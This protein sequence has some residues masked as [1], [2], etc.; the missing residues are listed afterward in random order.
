[1]KKLFVAILRHARDRYADRYEPRGA[2]DFAA[3]VWHALIVATFILLVAAIAISER[4][5]YAILKD[6]GEASSAPLPAPVVNRAT[7]DSTLQAYEARQATYDALTS[8][9]YQP[10]ADPSR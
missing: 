7:L 3:L 4:Q 8:G 1:M 2:R 10:P 9:S 6:L 5:L